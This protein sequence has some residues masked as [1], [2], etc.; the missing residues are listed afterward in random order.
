VALLVILGIVVG[1]LAVIFFANK[2][3][4]RVQPIA[5]V[6]VEATSPTA[7]QG[8]AEEPDP[9]ADAE[10]MEL[11]EPE[12]EE[13]LDILSELTLDEALLSDEALEK[14]EKSSQGDAR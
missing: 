9:P 2:F 8:F 1:S 12:L 11:I 13:T 3:A 10:A 7:N 5:F 14:A 4:S 6:P